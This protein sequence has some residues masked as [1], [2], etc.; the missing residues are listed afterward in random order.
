MSVSKHDSKRIQF[1]EGFQ[2]LQST[3]QD[4]ILVTM[5]SAYFIS[6]LFF[7][8]ENNVRAAKPEDCLTL[9]TQH[10][11]QYLKPP[12]I[13]LFK[14]DTENTD[15]SNTEMIYQTILRGIPAN[16]IDLK[17]ISLSR[18]HSIKSLGVNQSSESLNAILFS[19]LDDPI[20]QMNNLRAYIDFIE[21]LHPNSAK[22][23][24]LAILLNNG[25][26]LAYE[27]ESMYKYAWSK[28]FLDFSIVEKYFNFLSKE[29][30][31]IFHYY[32][33]FY[34]IIDKKHFHTRMELFPN[35]LRDV[36]GCVFKLGLIS[37]DAYTNITKNAKGNIVGVTG[38][39]IP[40]LLEILKIMNFS[41]EYVEVAKNMSFGKG[42]NVLF[43]KLRNNDLNM[44][45][46]PRIFSLRHASSFSQVDLENTV[47]FVSVVPILSTISINIPADLLS[48]AL[49]IPLGVV[50][51]CYFAIVLKIQQDKLSPFSILQALFG[52]PLTTRPTKTGDRMI[53]LSII[54][55]SLWYSIDFYS[56]FLNFQLI[57]E[58][59]FD[60]FESIDESNLKLYVND[61]A[62]DFVFS[63]ED[64]RIQNLK[65]KAE[66]V[67]DIA[68]CMSLLARGAN[69]VCVLQEDL[70]KIYIMALSSKYAEK[71]K[72]A[73]PV[74]N[75][76]RM[77]Y[78]FERSS[79]YTE[80]FHAILRKIYESG[81]DKTLDNNKKLDPVFSHS[82]EIKE[83]RIF[84]LQLIA[85]L[86]CGYMISLFVFFIECMIGKVK[87][88]SPEQQNIS[89][90]RE[91]Y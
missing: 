81:I 49:I 65:R 50:I 48:S 51:I 56:N 83:G 82:M 10:I 87:T 36:N 62:F 86:A 41:P 91:W 33:P 35:K 44:H 24:I 54:L 9:I 23:K 75:S 61:Y 26:L 39:K 21:E 30:N 14:N 22:P 37:T 79:P 2:R 85:I 45:V 3:I 69:L 19:G 6:L 84:V 78:Y 80:A 17:N 40:V 13:V 74:F 38:S 66:Q 46:V 31:C 77:V 63:D 1:L 25:S 34:E 12:H 11:T 90:L 16:I 70:A 59:P 15:T 67:E 5:W 76:Q 73:K 43:E 8:I 42:I 72:I 28:K 32:N 64:W 60:T 89:R 29:H 27:I 53:F 55:V 88:P 47:R 20:N 68:S 7:N 58:R 18:S 57:R 4:L 52:I 71:L